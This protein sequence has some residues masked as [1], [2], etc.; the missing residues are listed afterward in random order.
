VGGPRGRGLG[1][2]LILIR[3]GGG[4]MRRKIGAESVR[5]KRQ[6]SF[7]VKRRPSLG[8]KKDPPVPVS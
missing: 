4:F 6:L 2:S 1:L 5:E 3:G 7:K 8:K